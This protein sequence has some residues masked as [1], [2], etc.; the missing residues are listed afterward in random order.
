MRQD[1]IILNLQRACE[2]SIYIAMH[3]VRIHK[4][5]ILQE[6]REVFDM[7]A[8]DWRTRRA[9]ERD[10]QVLVEIVLDVCQRLIS[11]ANEVPPCVRVVV[12]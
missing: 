4:L 6:S 10:L 1:S 2:A 9:I 8:D 3:L 7:L 5:G 12:T 11:L